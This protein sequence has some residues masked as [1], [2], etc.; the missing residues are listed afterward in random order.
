MIVSEIKEFRRTLQPWRHGQEDHLLGTYVSKLHKFREW[1]TSTQVCP[2]TAFLAE[3]SS[4]L[5]YIFDD[6]KLVLTIKNYRSAIGAIRRGFSDSSTIGNNSFIIQ[7]LGGLAIDRPRTRSLAPSW[8][9]STV[10][11]PLARAP[12]ETMHKSSLADLTH[13][14]LF[15]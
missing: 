11:F 15:S 8:S 3:I 13:K 9:I 10:L 1:C 6:R 14:I 4:F 12:Y 2:S 5:R 7:L